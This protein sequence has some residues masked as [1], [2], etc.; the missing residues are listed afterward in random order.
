MRDRR[1]LKS[2]AS[3]TQ[4]RNQSDNGSYLR[5]RI[6]RMLALLVRLNVHL[7]LAGARPVVEPPQGDLETPAFYAGRLRGRIRSALNRTHGFKLKGVLEQADFEIE[8]QTHA[9]EP[10]ELFAGT[11]DKVRL[12]AQ[13][14]A[15]GEELF[16]QA[17]GPTEAALA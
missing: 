1:S 9:A 2:I 17:D 12:M 8:P 13:R 16:H 15:R 7:E 5:L 14:L 11:A 3:S 10:T 4:F 6:K